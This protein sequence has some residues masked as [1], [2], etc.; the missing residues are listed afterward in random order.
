MEDIKSGMAEMKKELSLLSSKVVLLMRAS[1]LGGSSDELPA[2][3]K[4]PINS[5]HDLA[6]LEHS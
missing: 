1:G 3:V 2:E 6:E 4:L 5:S